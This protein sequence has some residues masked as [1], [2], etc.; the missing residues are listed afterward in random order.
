M[1]ITS[2]LIFSLILFSNSKT[3]AQET[4]LMKYIDF[5]QEWTLYKY[6]GEALPKIEVTPHN[7][8]QIFAYG[9]YVYAQAEY[10]KQK[11]AK[12]L[13]VYDKKRRTIY[14]SDEIS[15]DD[16]MRDVTLVHEF[17]HYMQDIN[18]Y[19]DSLNGH[20]EC[21]ES[22]AYDVQILWQVIYKIDEKSVPLANQLSLI[23]A[24]KCM[25]TQ[26]FKFKN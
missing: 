15:L 22:E 21:T 23:S 12:I 17:V 8:V 19:T 6:N 10:K 20:I 1:R 26:S 9:D 14:I 4:D 11:L 18:G 24:M 3:Y 7:L 25:G 2:L 16:P 13:S 5:V